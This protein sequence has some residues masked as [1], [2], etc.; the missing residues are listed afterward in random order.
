MTPVP[1]SSAR[2]SKAC[3]AILAGWLAAPALWS[4]GARASH[5]V[6][7]PPV[8]VT[9]ERLTD[10]RSSGPVAGCAVTGVIQ[11]PNREALIARILWEAHDASGRALGFFALRVPRLA[12]GERRPF[13]SASLALLCS[14]VQVFERRE[15]VTE[16]VR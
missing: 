2:R 12:P 8:T 9:A 13:T 7:G 4:S 11:N 16:P 1:G 5:F 3:R 14:R 6:E 10:T 15:L